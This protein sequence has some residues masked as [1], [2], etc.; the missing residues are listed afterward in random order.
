MTLTA[1]VA[2]VLLAVVPHEREV[3][4]ELLDALVQARLQLVLDLG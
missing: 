1:V 4:L 2:V 3:G